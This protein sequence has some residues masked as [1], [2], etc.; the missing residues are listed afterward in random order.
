MASVKSD[1]LEG[2]H[3]VREYLDELT[4]D[5]WRAL[6]VILACGKA[7]EGTTDK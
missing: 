6:I 3:A 7:S 5:E 4:M 1:F 2:L